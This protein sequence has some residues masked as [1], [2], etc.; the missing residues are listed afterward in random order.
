M[1]GATDDMLAAAELP[2]GDVI[3]ILL[4]Q[5]AR[6]RTLFTD[7]HDAVGSERGRLFAELRALLVVH[8]TAEQLI[9]RPVSSQVTDDAV[10]QGRIEEEA[11]ATKVL[12]DLDQM[13]P[14][15]AEFHALFTAFERSV[16][17]HAEAEETL[18]F[19]AVVAGCS[20]EQRQRLGSVLMAAER[21][22][23]TRPHPAVAGHATATVLT[24]PIASIVDRTRD[25]IAK[26]S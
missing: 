12:A 24:L 22:A 2:E 19:P 5:H 10:V 18:E 4:E 7:V 3:R 11:D 14:D 21:I 23:P 25:A 26:A 8:E 20:V 1:P 9:V 15:S 6:I 13:A 17:E 16:V